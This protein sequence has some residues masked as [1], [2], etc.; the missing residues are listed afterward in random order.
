MSR[1]TEQPSPRAE[2]KAYDQLPK[3]LRQALS[4]SGEQ[5]SASQILRLWQSRQASIAELIA[6][7]EE[8]DR[9][10]NP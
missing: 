5:F 1:T 2:M 4:A 8:E 6:M 3:T 10:S 9:D 7:I